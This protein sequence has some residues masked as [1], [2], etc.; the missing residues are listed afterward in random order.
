L[1]AETSDNSDDITH[2]VHSVTGHVARHPVFP[3]ARTRHRNPGP[4]IV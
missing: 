3:L 4:A 1:L 2:T